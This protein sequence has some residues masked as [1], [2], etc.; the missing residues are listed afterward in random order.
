L[1]YFANERVKHVAHFPQGQRALRM[2]RL[3]TQKLE[4]VLIFTFDLL[5]F[6]VREN[7]PLLVNHT[8]AGGRVKNNLNLMNSTKSHLCKCHLI[9]RPRRC[10]NGNWP[11][12]YAILEKLLFCRWINGSNCC[13]R[14]HQSAVVVAAA[15]IDFKWTV[16]GREEAFK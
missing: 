7:P 5:H 8:L 2:S 16:L 11:P 13:L 10:M 1:P 15:D 4:K 12:I 14:G 3:L 6:Q 9:N